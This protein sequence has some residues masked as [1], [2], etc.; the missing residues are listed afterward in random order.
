MES[1]WQNHKKNEE[2]DKSIQSTKQ[3]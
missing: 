2:T 3:G 1:R